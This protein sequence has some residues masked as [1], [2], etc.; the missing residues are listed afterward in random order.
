MLKNNKNK[1]IKKPTIASKYAKFS[2]P[3][4][5]HGNKNINSKSNNKNTK[6]IL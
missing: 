6:A 4:N 2:T 1:K 5:V 3:V